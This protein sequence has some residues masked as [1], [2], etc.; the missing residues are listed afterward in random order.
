MWFVRL[1]KILLWIGIIVNIIFASWYVLHG[2]IIFH[3]DIARDFILL[4]EVVETHKPALL[5]PRTGAIPGVFHGPAW[6]YLN[7]PAFILGDGNPL[8]VGW[9]WVVM[10]IMMIGSV[11]FLGKKVFSD[12]IGLIAAALISSRAA[13]FTHQFFNP[14][15]ISLFFPIFFYTLWK[16]FETKRAKFLVFSVL[17]SGLLIHFEVVFGMPMYLGVCLLTIYLAIKKQVPLKFLLYLGVII[18]PLSNY[19]LFDLRHQFVQTRS[20]IQY[21]SADNPTYMTMREILSN[22]FIELTHSLGILSVGSYTTHTFL[23]LVFFLTL[24]LG[25]FK[26]KQK[27]F[28]KLYILLYLL[29]WSF[30]ILI[31]EKIKG[32]YFDFTAINVLIFVSQLYAFKKWLLVGVFLWIF[33]INT[34]H[35]KV[36][37]FSTTDF[38][39][40]VVSSWQFNKEMAKIVVQD[41]PDNFSLFTLDTDIFGYTANYAVRYIAQRAGKNVN[42]INKSSVT[43]ILIASNTIDHPNFDVRWWKDDQIRVPNRPT[44]KV[45]YRG[46]YWIE[47]YDLTPEEVLVPEDP[48]LMNNKL[49]R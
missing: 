21:I 4:N 24:L 49:L 29:F 47:R 27:R 39:G 31:P 33:T 45:D 42:T 26:S 22:R 20:F 28:F 36:V 16:F 3:S 44:S 40:K 32:Y 18:L 2:D 34:K 19:I 37:A 8:V 23:S 11:Y 1:A 14:S 17:L 12:W 7:L 46:L 48:F 6:L 30:S 15:G 10:E 38:S 43:Y 13:L 41:A 9:G 5:G 25:L 35:A